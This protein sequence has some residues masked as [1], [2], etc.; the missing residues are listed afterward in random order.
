[1]QP[2]LL[3]LAAGMGSRYG[4]LK[5]ID[6]IGPNG[7]TIIDYSVYDAIK[8][9]FGKVVFVIRKDIETEFKAVVGSRYSDKIKVEYAFQDGND[10][11]EGF[12]VPEGREKPWGTAHAVRAA[13]KV[14]KEPFVIINGDDFYGADAYKTVASYLQDNEKQACMV[15]YK[16]GKTLSSNGSV[17]RGICKTDED[18]CL[19][20]AIETHGIEKKSGDIVDEEGNKLNSDDIASMNFWAANPEIFAVIEEMFIDFLKEKGQEMKSEFYIPSIFTHLINN[21]NQKVKVLKNDSSWYGVTYREDK[22]EVQAAI[23][24]MVKAG[25]Y[26]SPLWG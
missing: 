16:L 5:Q 23:A 10:L 12:T 18:D 7:E 13:R 14:V 15:G 9:G 4:G 11:P 3:V 24:D 17:S 8:A 25:D 20:E 21:L 26:P 6:S 1:M 19:I 2:T 22:A